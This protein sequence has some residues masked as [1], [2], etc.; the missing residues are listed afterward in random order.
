MAPLAL[1]LVPVNH[2]IVG[3]TLKFTFQ[4][5]L[6]PALLKAMKATVHVDCKGLFTRLKLTPR[7]SCLRAFYVPPSVP[8]FPTSILD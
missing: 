4:V 7:W 1:Y 6:V 8:L 2:K 5:E 3:Q